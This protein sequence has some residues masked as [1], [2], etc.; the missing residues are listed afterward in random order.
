MSH[1]NC[2]RGLQPAFAFAL[3]SGVVAG[4]VGRFA[5]AGFLVLVAAFGVVFWGHGGPSEGVEGVFGLF[6]GISREKLSLGVMKSVILGG[7]DGG[8]AASG[9]CDVG[10]LRYREAVT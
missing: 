6:L 4:G 3:G 1:V 5:F 7:C 2:R 8:A 9:R 10:G